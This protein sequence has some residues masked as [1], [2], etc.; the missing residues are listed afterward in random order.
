[1]DILKQENDQ[2]RR[3]RE[4]AAARAREENEAAGRAGVTRTPPSTPQKTAAADADAAQ[5][6]NVFVKMGGQFRR[7]SEKTRASLSGTPSLG[8]ISESS[9][10]AKEEL[11]FNPFRA[12][13][14]LPSKM[15]Q[16]SLEAAMSVG[17]NCVSERHNP[18]RHV[19]YSGERIPRVAPQGVT[20]GG[21]PTRAA[22]Q[23]AAAFEAAQ[24]ATQQAMEALQK[25]EADREAAV[26]A[27]AEHEASMNRL[28]QEVEAK[29]RRR[30]EQEQEVAKQRIEAMREAQ[31]EKAAQQAVRE[32]VAEREAAAL[33]EA[34]VAREVAAAREAAVAR[35]VAA[36]RAVQDGRRAAEASAPPPPSSHSRGKL[37]GVDIRQRAAQRARAGEAAA[38]NPRG[39]F[40]GN[41][42]APAEAWAWE[43][44]PRGHS[45]SSQ[46]DDD[47]GMGV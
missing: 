2:L 4:E 46:E 12:L 29:E 47:D 17:S 26:A 19:A 11:G 6:Q 14:Q 27:A 35:E 23:Q 28:R 1:M 10:S 42:S 43:T 31:A 30:V 41:A 45:V 24:A 38:Y 44:R 13:A 3:E 36:Q 34:A 40:G 15:V 20:D 37:D 5:S 33:R 22:Q 32:A 25:A 39:G 8:T 21:Q 7:V 9:P 16:S 18:R